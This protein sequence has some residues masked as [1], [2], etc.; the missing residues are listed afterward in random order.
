MTANEAHEEPDVKDAVPDTVA[1]ERPRR[2]RQP[3]VSVVA[4]SERREAAVVTAARALADAGWMLPGDT[5]EKTFGELRRYLGG[6]TE[7]HALT[8]LSLRTQAFIV[9]D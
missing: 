2:K 5:F 1:E 6:A 7:R 9:T 4:L 3:T 8:W